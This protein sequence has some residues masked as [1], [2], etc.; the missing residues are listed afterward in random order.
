MDSKLPA[1][2]DQNQPLDA[3]VGFNE[4]E[5]EEIRTQIDAIANENRLPPSSDLFNL[6][7]VPRGFMLPAMVLVITVVVA[8][9]ATLVMRA[10]FTRDEQSIRRGAG[11]FVSVEGRLI[12]AL[13]QESNEQLNAKQAEIS[14]IRSRLEQLEAEQRALE[15][16]FDQR[17][18][19]REE[20]LREQLEREI[21]TE[22][23]RLIAQ[24]L[25]STE[26]ERLMQ[27]FEAERRAFYES[28]LQQYRAELEAERSAIQTNIDTLR[29]ELQTRIG[30]LERERALLREEFQQRENELRAELQ[31]RT[32]L[33]A[34]ASTEA[35]QAAE[36]AQRELQDITTRANQE[37]AMEMQ[38]VGQL[39][40][41]RA[42]LT[43]DELDLAL[44]R[45]EST[46][47]FLN[48]NRIARFRTIA[49]RRDADLFLL[50]QLESYI[51]QR[52]LTAGSDAEI[53]EQQTEGDDQPAGPTTDELSDQIRVLQA[54]IDATEAQ[55]GSLAEV[56][57]AEREQLQQRIDE[58]ATYQQQLIAARDRYE[59]F[60]SAISQARA[61]NP[62]TA[63]VA[64][65][66]ELDELLRSPAFGQLFGQLSVE[67]SR[68]LAES[69]TAGSDAAVA[70]AADIVSRIM[71]EPTAQARLGRLR[72]EQS[73][74]VDNP[75]LSAILQALESALTSGS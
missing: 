27:Q 59:T 10:L 70:D 74:A 40:R 42:A 1:A 25:G 56:S 50:L 46:R 67:V 55:L 45:I 54:A 13:R 73:D 11:E 24:G 36:A 5:Q 14:A 34:G 33:S 4:R 18:A 61:Q 52:L 39:E 12:R 2:E 16:D 32:Q 49:V 47:E 6:A 65:R 63:S 8:V 38:L 57:I 48:D 44:E 75:D 68:L 15:S 62:A 21:A 51:H 60:I 71:Q 69:A 72:F 43:E 64:V 66:Q 7:S 31:G 30:Q 22:R 19:R 26:I 53:R 23:A 28:Q 20:E 3:T 58:L 29:S 37:R 41:I 35:A 17:L 9:S